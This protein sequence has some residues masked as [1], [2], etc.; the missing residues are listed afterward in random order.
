V[1]LF[2]YNKTKFNS[3]GTDVIGASAEGRLI[4]PTGGK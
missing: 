1:K 4:Y 2:T 3:Y